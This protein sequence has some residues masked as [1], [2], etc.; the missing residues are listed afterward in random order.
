MP[1]G[2]PMMP[3]D[4]STRRNF[5]TVVFNGISVTQPAIDAARQATPTPP[6]TQPTT[7]ADLPRMTRSADRSITA[8]NFAFLA[9]SVSGFAVHGLSLVISFTA[10][11]FRN[12]GGGGPTPRP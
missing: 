10:A 8:R 11:E 7:I 9:A 6:S 1:T 12:R 5:T 2:S 3:V 4:L